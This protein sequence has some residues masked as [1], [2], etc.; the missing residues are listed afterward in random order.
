MW[1]NSLLEKEWEKLGLTENVDD[2]AEIIN[3]HVLSSLNECAPI[4]TIKI[5]NQNRH[6][7]S[8]NTKNLIKERDN[9]RSKIRTASPKEK[10]IIHSKY[11]R[12]RNK[13]NSELRK[14]TIRSF[15]FR[16]LGYSHGPKHSKTD[17]WKTGPFVQFLNGKN[18]MAYKI[19]PQPFEYLTIPQPNTF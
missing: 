18:K 11:K 9:T 3:S 4:K 14:D 13:V 6:G 7:I 1:S 5:R 15:V 19:V 17:H 2:M 10:S 16:W 8:S 12:L